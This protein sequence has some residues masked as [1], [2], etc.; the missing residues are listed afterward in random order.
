MHFSRW[1]TFTHSPVFGVD[2]CSVPFACLLQRYKQNGGY[3]AGQAP[4]DVDL[5]KPTPEATG[6][7]ARFIKWWA[8]GRPG[9]PLN[10][11]RG[12]RKVC[13]H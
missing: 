3:K 5:S 6:T 7:L 13:K 11:R 10:R 12:G 4:I 2:A 9:D 8:D 1:P